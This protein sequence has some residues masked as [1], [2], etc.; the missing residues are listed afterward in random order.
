MEYPAFR[1]DLTPCDF[2]LCYM[3][4]QLKG[5]SFSKEEEF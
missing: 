2:L 5:R 4:E 1:S 3:K